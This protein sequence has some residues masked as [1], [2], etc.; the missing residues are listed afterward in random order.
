ME[1]GTQT[2]QSAEDVIGET[3]GEVLGRIYIIVYSVVIPTFCSHTQNWSYG[4]SNLKH[5]LSLI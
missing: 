4:V 3:R 1:S 5:S 2:V